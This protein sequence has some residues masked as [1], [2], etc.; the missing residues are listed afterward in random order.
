MV[1]SASRRMERLSSSHQR[2]AEPNA[3]WGV[4]ISTIQTQT[5]LP[6]LSFENR[7]TTIESCCSVMPRLNPFK[8]C[9]ILRFVSDSVR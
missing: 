6:S 5:V 9:D 1:A 4:S 7:G 3:R 8:G 2:N